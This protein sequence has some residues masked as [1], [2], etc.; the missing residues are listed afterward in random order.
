MDCHQE[1]LYLSTDKMGVYEGARMNQS[2]LQFMTECG[3]DEHL[4]VFLIF[5]VYE[6]SCT[7]SIQFQPSLWRFSVFAKRGSIIKVFFF[8]FP[9]DWPNC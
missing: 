4:W 5:Y 2:S 9:S 3:K 6:C 7:H 8:K 1:A